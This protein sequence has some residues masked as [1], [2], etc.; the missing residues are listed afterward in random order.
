MTIH[1]DHPFLP[2]EGE[3]SPVRRF[4]GRLATGVT[5]WTS[6]Y[7]GR[8]AGLTVS[9]M[10]VADGDPA[11]LLALIDPDSDLWE[12]LAESETVAVSVLGYDDRA[13]AEAFAGVAP[14]PGGPFR[15]GSWIETEWGPVLD[16]AYPWAGGRLLDDGTREVGWALLVEAV[17]EH[18]DLRT[19]DSGYLTHHRARYHRLD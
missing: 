19:A 16:S 8:R 18:V 5:V 14:A 13:L 15:L 1:G 6:A 4:R 17:L 2:P 10:M 3:R 7:G 9:S 11:R 12:V